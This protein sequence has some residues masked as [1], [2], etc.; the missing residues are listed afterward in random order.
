[1]EE[2]Y[3]YIIQCY[4][5][6]CGHI[7]FTGAMYLSGLQGAAPLTHSTQSKPDDFRLPPPPEEQTRAAAAAAMAKL[8]LLCLKCVLL[9]ST[10]AAVFEDQVGKFD[11]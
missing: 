7:V 3:F 9:C 1:M 2:H 8:T 6:F 4:M 10:V 5:S 11:W